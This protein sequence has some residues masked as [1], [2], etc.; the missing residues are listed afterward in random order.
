MSVRIESHAEPLPGYRLIERLGGGG[1]GEVWK[2]EAPGGLH[3]AIKF[4]YGDLQAADEDGARAEQE[5]KALSRVKTVHHPYILSLERY[6]IID[7]QLIIVMELADRTLWDRFRECR[8]QGLPGIPRDELLRYMGETAEA[9]DLMNSLYQLQHLDIKPQ[10]LFLVHNHVKVADFGLVKDLEGMMAS[11]TGGVTPVYAAPETFDGWVSRFSDQYS[12]AIVY[13]ELLT[14]QRPFTG[15]TIR[16]LVLQHLQ[17]TPDLSSLP[18]EDRAAISRALAKKPEER[19]PTCEGLVQALRETPQPIVVGPAPALPD[20]PRESALP[21]PFKS[22]ETLPPESEDAD[23]THGGLGHRNGTAKAREPKH[24]TPSRPDSAV[25]V[26]PATP[27]TPVIA[28][29]VTPYWPAA[30][31]VAQGTPGPA[32]DTDG[33]VVPR[34]PPTEVKGD[35]VLRPALVIGLGQH[36]LDILKR[37]RRELFEQFG[38]HDAAPHLRML[39]LDTDPEALQTATGGSAEVALRSAEV[40]QTRLHRPSYYLKPGLD[41]Q[42][43]LVS[44]LNPK[45]LYRMPRQPTS[46]GLRALG[47]LAFV[48]NHRA[49]SRRLLSELEACCAKDALSLASQ[50]TGLG[51]RSNT[52]RVYVATSLAGG[53]GS[54]MFLDVAYAMRHLLRRLGYD[55]A[56]IVGLFL[57]P[58][59]ERGSGPSPGLANAFAAL[60]EL[61]HFA[62]PDTVFQARYETIDQQA[63]TLISEAGP[64][65]QRCVL[66]P[67]PERRG[68]GG[69]SKRG[70]GDGSVEPPAAGPIGLAGRFL[71]TELATPLGQATEQARGQIATTP[72]YQT[73]GMYRLLWP[74][75]QLLQ[76]VARDLC[77]RLVQRWMS[78]EAKLLRDGVHQ[79][80]EAQWVEQGLTADQLI[81]RL[82]EEVERSLG[83]APET[84]FAAMVASLTG[85]ADGAPPKTPDTLKPSAVVEAMEQLEQL[86]GIPEE[87]RPSGPTPSEPK[88][89]TVED[90]VRKAAAKAAMEVEQRLAELLVRLIEEPAFRLAGAEE[91]NRQFSTVVERALQHQEHLVRELQLRALGLYQRIHTLL[92]NPGPEPP[93]TSLWKTPFSRRAASDKAAL[94]NELL[95]LLRSYSKC[96]YQ[97]LILQ[98]LTQLYLSVRGLL[99]E[100]MHEIGFCRQRLSELAGLFGN[101]GEV[102]DLVP[103][104]GRCL[105]PG[106]CESLREA[107][108]QM[109]NGFTAAD[110]HALDQRIQALLRKQY[111]ALV[112]VCTAMSNVIRNVAPAMQQETEAFLGERLGGVS[113]TDMYLAQNAKAEEGSPPEAAVQKDLMRTF[114]LADTQLMVE[115]GRDVCLLALPSGAGEQPFR[116]LA[117]TALPEAPLAATAGSDEILMYREQVG[118]ALADLK[119]LGPVGRDAYQQMAALQHFTPHSRADITNWRAAAAAGS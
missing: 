117:R 59:A 40:L 72:V 91:A 83:Y 2:C 88:V 31:P 13:Q 37:L 53:T 74:R 56:E 30:D 85:S 22:K 107:V 18:P 75:R 77:R 39:Y 42:Q 48:D 12:L 78:K 3:K 86:V 100:Q 9:L 6:D 69:W 111:R 46:A 11:V 67:L 110:L 51:V 58:N 113:V 79:W 24:E 35:G 89:G 17:A 94:V 101:E 81:L 80:V 105:L 118:F 95:G 55:R 112:H 93:T 43:R 61:N 10:N 26:P 4:V 52:P 73:F 97:S 90:A 41:G 116:D 54:G 103:A 33:E 82:Q 34:P 71:I 15:S 36:G 8:D 119:Q 115:A 76:Q 102:A 50:R 70:H 1:F 65:F 23:K 49:I 84:M 106:G 5:L 7:G 92:E 63:A 104:A 20:L 32:S 87:C 16:Q 27:V 25:S 28:Q 45:L 99:S 64:P 38:S 47:R 109:E 98:Y 60:T 44:W 108:K 29:P 114:D 68:G 19:F 14:A 57:L 62:P 96:R 66:L 21:T